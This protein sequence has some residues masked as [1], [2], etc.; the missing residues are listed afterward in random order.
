M[1]TYTN[2]TTLIHI[3]FPLTWD[4]S[5]LSAL[6][7]QIADHDA[8]ELMA[9]TAATLYT[10]TTLDADVLRYASTVTLAATAGNVVAGNV[11]RIV[12]A[13]GYEDRVIKGYDTTTKIAT[14]EQ[15]VDNEYVDGDDVYLLSA[16]VTV[17]LSNTTT[18]PLG[19]SMVFTW[20]P[21]G[22]GSP[23]TQLREIGSTI[24]VDVEG[25]EVGMRALFRRAYDG[26]KTPEDRLGT[27]LD[28]AQ[29]DLRRQL[30]SRRL[31]I[32]RVMD[33]EVLEPSLRL[34]CAIYWARGG[35]LVDGEKL[36][37]KDELAEYR[38]DYSIEFELLC[39]N[40]IW[41]DTDMDNIEDPG[42][43]VSHEYYFRKGW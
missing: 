2:S 15:I 25:F 13:A 8:V 31:D 14:L 42:E 10:A 9:A 26:L 16:S 17:D 30:I 36:S 29:K 20:T 33:Q 39:K 6:T 35:E 34:L 38:K 28:E 27:V 22:T 19:Q 23:F 7:L 21:T 18:F 24:Q 41:V 11:I 5:A 43:T 4:P 32:T 3:D 37:L 12:G 40:P 1:I